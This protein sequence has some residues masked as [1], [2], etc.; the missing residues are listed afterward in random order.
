M[1]EEIGG[2][3]RFGSLACICA[4]AIV[5]ML[6]GAYG[7][8]FAVDDIQVQRD[9]IRIPNDYLAKAVCIGLVIGAGAGV[10][11]LRIKPRWLEWTGPSSTAFITA[12]SCAGTA[13]VLG[14]G[15]YRM[16]RFLG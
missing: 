1:V 14:L 11:A 4:N 10:A 3:S 15:T 16:C 9:W 5:G 8:Y 13:L 2:T 7:A 12:V 6:A